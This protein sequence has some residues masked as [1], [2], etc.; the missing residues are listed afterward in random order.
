M[1]HPVGTS[2]N[3]KYHLITSTSTVPLRAGS[4]YR[5]GQGGVLSGV[6]RRRTNSVLRWQPVCRGASVAIA[7]DLLLSL[8][9]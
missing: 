9:C 6:L 5:A 4:C 3:F 7:K 8:S 2:A 1:K